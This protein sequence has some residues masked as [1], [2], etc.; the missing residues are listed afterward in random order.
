[1]TG[2]SKVR[3]PAT[4]FEVRVLVAER[5]ALVETTREPGER[6]ALGAP[7]DILEGVLKRPARPPKSLFARLKV[8]GYPD[9]RDAW[10]CDCSTGHAAAAV[11]AL[12]AKTVG[13]LVSLRLVDFHQH[14]F[15]VL[16]GDLAAG[17]DLS[18][19]EDRRR[20]ELA[21]ASQHLGLGHWAAGA[22]LGGA[23]D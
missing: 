16:G 5:G 15:A 10:H 11:E 17:I 20:V 7:A 21:L 18:P 3:G 4:V 14:I 6:D 9:R 23:V 8:L 1:L 22:Q 13:E 2:E 12:E 19:V